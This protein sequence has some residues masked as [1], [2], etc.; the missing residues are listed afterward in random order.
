MGT[1]SLPPEPN[2]PLVPP[3]SQ[4]GLG[5]ANACF[6]YLNN[7][8][9]DIKTIVFSAPLLGMVYGFPLIFQFFEINICRA[10]KPIYFPP[11]CLELRLVW[12][13]FLHSASFLYFNSPCPSLMFLGDLSPQAF[14]ALALLLANSH[15]LPRTLAGTCLAQVVL[16]SPAG[17]SQVLQFGLSAGPGVFT[18]PAPYLQETGRGLFP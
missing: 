1:L 8:L 15:G 11:K 17:L 14:P 2:P 7:T 13:C 16:F 3:C 5:H 10:W 9:E 12:V 4:V 6:I 18:G